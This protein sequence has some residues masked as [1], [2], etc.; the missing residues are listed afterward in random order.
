MY[1]TLAVMF[2]LTRFN[3]CS[4]GPTLSH[5]ASAH[6]RSASSLAMM[7]LLNLVLLYIFSTCMHKMALHQVRHGANEETNHA[8]GLFIPSASRRTENRHLERY[9]CAGAYPRAYPV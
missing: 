6:S 3:K 8:L 7:A 5:L 2:Y 1:K 9:S 4:R